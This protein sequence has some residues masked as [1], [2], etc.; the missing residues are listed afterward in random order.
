MVYRTKAEQR[1]YLYY[2]RKQI[3]GEKVSIS[4]KLRSDLG[5]K[6]KKK[7]KKFIKFI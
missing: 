3:R 2:R 7:K 6:R 5:S 4:R 1:S